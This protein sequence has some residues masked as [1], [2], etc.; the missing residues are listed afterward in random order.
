MQTM[1]AAQRVERRGSRKHHRRSLEC[2]RTESLKSARYSNTWTRSESARCGNGEALDIVYGT[3][4]FM[5]SESVFLFRGR[6]TSSETRPRS[7]SKWVR[8]SR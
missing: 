8:V 1:I 4:A 5:V 6:Q 7:K 2:F 3:D